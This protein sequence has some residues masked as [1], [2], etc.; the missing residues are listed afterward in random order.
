M[1]GELEFAEGMAQSTE[2]MT[3]PVRSVFDEQRLLAY[4]RLNI[5]EFPQHI[6]TLQIR[7]VPIVINLP[8]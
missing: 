2:E 7:Q 3:G 1:T 6:A 8:N 4:L 5:P